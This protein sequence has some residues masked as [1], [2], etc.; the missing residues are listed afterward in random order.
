MNSHAV[1][2]LNLFR[3]LL[4]SDLPNKISLS[5]SPDDRDCGK[6]DNLPWLLCAFFH[7]ST[8]Q[9]NLVLSCT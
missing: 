1:M 3:G 9:N 6:T 5:F 4:A 8:H 7:A 2:F